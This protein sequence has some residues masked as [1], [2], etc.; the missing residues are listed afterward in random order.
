M[1][2]QT[3]CPPYY[4]YYQVPPYPYPSYQPA[5]PLPH[6]AQVHPEARRQFAATLSPDDLVGNAFVQNLEHTVRTLRD[7]LEK[8]RAG[9]RRST[10]FGQTEHRSLQD[11][12]EIGQNGIVG[13]I[14]T[15][16]VTIQDLRSLMD[17]HDVRPERLVLRSGLWNTTVP[18]AV[19]VEE[20]IKAFGTLDKKGRA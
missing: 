3:G 4:P 16:R 15:S 17:L 19:V 14:A 12:A 10:Y 8:E 20:F 11:W 7:S 9:R 18:R 13:E 2:P 6:P 1:Q 5:A